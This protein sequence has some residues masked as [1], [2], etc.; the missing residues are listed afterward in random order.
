MQRYKHQCYEI[1]YQRKKLSTIT[2]SMSDLWV[3][4]SFVSHC[5]G[6]VPSCKHSL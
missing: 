2:E 3:T 4:P 6:L 1:K 5:F